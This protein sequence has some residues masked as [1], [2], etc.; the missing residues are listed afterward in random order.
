MIRALIVLHGN[1]TDISGILDIY[2]S[3]TLLICADGG[4]EYAREHNLTPDLVVGDMDSIS[5]ETM[6]WLEQQKVKI[7]KF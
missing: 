7:L 4:A 2:S 5:L 3:K 1:K 6:S